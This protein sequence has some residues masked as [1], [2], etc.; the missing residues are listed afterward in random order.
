MNNRQQIIGRFFAEEW[1]AALNNAGN[2]FNSV[3]SDIM[4]LPELYTLRAKLEELVSFWDNQ[5]YSNTS[6]EAILNAT[7]IRDLSQ[8]RLDATNAFI[9]SK[10]GS[11]ATV[12]PQILPGDQPTVYT[13]TGEQKKSWLPIIIIGAVALYFF[14]KKKQRAA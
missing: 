4:S 6:E 2:F 14:T 7:A 12:T 5:I 1:Q 3:P 11:T 10:S 13:E 8:S 9:Q